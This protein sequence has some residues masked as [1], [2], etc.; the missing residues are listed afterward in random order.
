MEEIIKQSFNFAQIKLFKN[1]SDRTIQNILYSADRKL[2]PD[3]QSEI[4]SAVELDVFLKRFSA[5]REISNDGGSDLITIK[6]IVPTK[7]AGTVYNLRLYPKENR[8]FFHIGESV[9]DCNGS[10]IIRSEGRTGRRYEEI[11]IINTKTS[12]NH[13]NFDYFE[14]IKDRQIKRYYNNPFASIKIFQIER[15]I[16]KEGNKITIKFFSHQRTRALIVCTS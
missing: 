10:S 5:V 1:Y 9:P 3:H 7:I 4:I 8:K 14:T 2:L 12:T 15:W 6:H 11:K 13:I 16:K